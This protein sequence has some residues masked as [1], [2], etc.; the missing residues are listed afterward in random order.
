[1]K[2]REASPLSPETNLEKELNMSSL[3]RIELMSALEDRYQVD[4]SEVKFSDAKTVGQ[5]ARILNEPVAPAKALA[6][7]RWGQSWPVTFIRL[8]VYYALVWPATYLLAAPRIRGRENLRNLHGPVLVISNHVTYV[9]IGWILA[10]LP[11]HF[12]HRLATAMRGER[13][14]TMLRPPKEMGLIERWSERISYFLVVA[15]FNVFALPREAGFLKSFSYAGD[16]ADRGWNILVFPEGITT[17]DGMLQ[18]FQS[19][20]GL[21]AKKLQIPVVP[22]HLAGLYDLKLANRIFAW[23]GTI[24]VS[25]GKPVQFSPDDVPA[26]IALE[27]ARRVADLENS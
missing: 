20:V 22:V 25:I 15:L 24:R 10:A 1:M 23:P 21:L 27:L 13:L 8:M 9:D 11:A 18:P 16:L 3:D 5:I 12:R 6:Y 7:P 14:A 26:Q 17:P 19:G 4:L 2:H